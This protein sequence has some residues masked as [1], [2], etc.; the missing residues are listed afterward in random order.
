MRGKGS[1]RRFGY[2]APIAVASAYADDV[3]DL[4]CA[5]VIYLLAEKKGITRDDLWAWVRDLDMDKAEAELFGKDEDRS[6]QVEA[7]ESFADRVATGMFDPACK[8]EERLILVQ[9]GYEPE[10]TIFLTEGHC[11]KCL[12]DLHALCQDY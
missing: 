2:G 9:E 11:S 5:T 12:C 1:S 10:Q 8:S 7:E 4:R 3:Y 6:V